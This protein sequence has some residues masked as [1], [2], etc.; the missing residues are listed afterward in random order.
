MRLILVRHGETDANRE[1]RIQGIGNDPLNATGRSQAAALGEH[2]ET[3]KLDAVYSS[4]L[5]RALE[6]AEAIARHHNLR[7]I[8]LKGL[9]ELDIGELDGLT[10]EEVKERH[11]DVLEE[12]M[13]DVSSLRMPGG[14]SI[15]ELQDRAW[16]AVQAIAEGHPKGV[17]V[18]VSHNFAIQSI[19]CKALDLKLDSFRRIRQD[20]GAISILEL[21]D[22][23]PILI[24]LNDRCHWA[25]S[26]R[27]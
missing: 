25:E 6:T 16:A 15:V 27:L 20:L 24:T 2:L 13:R 1:G 8:E 22:R 23:H 19:L 21:T 7:P 14:E 12:W 26:R 11:P 9:Q 17:V 3:Y 4:P 10:G 5:A 18:G